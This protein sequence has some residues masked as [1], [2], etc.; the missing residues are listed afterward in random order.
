MPDIEP[1]TRPSDPLAVIRRAVKAAVAYG[2]IVTTGPDL[3]VVCDST[4]APTWQRDERATTI[5]PLGAL[6]LVHNPP[7]S[8]PDEAIAHVLGTEPLWALGFDDGCSG[9][10]PGASAIVRGLGVRIY[11]SG[12]RAGAEFRALH[13]VPEPRDGDEVTE[14]VQ[15]EQP[16]S[17][18]H[19][20][21]ASL[22]LAEAME[23]VADTVPGRG[24]HVDTMA[25]VVEDLR[26]RATEYRAMG[27]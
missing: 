20:L 9:G 14:P 8:V 27:L 13:G 1:A 2:H 25:D 10:E 19:R 21:L 26:E 15:Q 18:L 12:F 23:A 22:T 7:V 16:A 17:I 5:S 24:W 11:G 6:L 3:G 4:H